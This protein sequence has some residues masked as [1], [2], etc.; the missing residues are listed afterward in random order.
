MMAGSTISTISL[1]NVG[2]LSIPVPSVDKQKEIGKAYENRIKAIQ[3][4]D[5][6]KELEEEKLNAMIAEVDE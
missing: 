4:A 6:L 5:R 1:K 3:L 2:A